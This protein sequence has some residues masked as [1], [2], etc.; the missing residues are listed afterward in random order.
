MSYFL[1]KPLDSIQPSK[2]QVHIFQ[3][4]AMLKFWFLT[5]LVASS[6]IGQQSE[7]GPERDD[8]ELKDRVLESAFEELETFKERWWYYPRMAFVKMIPAGPSSGVRGNLK[9]YQF[10]NGLFISGKLVGLTPGA[11]G[12]HV[13]VNGSTD[14]NCTLTGPHFN[15]D[16]VTHGAPNFG[17]RHAG[18][19]G[20]I[21][22]SSNGLAKIEIFTKQMTLDPR[23][24]YYIMGRSFV[25]HSLADDLGV[26]NA[27]SLIN[28]NSGVRLACGIIV[29][30]H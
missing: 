11:H 15:P 1:K 30:R 8:D 21:Y 6:V 5:L 23:S 2:S 24:K 22:A 9:I 3:K 27:T 14:L 17:V 20:N 16:N 28:G 29:Q 19:L 7:D 13:H 4:T 18:D 10:N 25:V 26:G 12:F